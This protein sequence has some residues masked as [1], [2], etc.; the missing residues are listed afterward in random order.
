MTGQILFVDG[1]VECSLREN[2][3]GEARF[4]VRASAAHL[5]NNIL[6]GIGSIALECI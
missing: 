1:G 5:W 3:R 4:N 2:D 6:Y